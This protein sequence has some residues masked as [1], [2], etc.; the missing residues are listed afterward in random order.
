MPQIQMYTKEFC[1]FCIRAKKLLNSLGHDFEE[2]EISYDAAKE[3][4]MI[5]RTGRYTVPQIFIGGLAI[6]GSDELVA[7]V[8]NGDFDYL[9]K[10]ANGSIDNPATLSDG[11]PSHV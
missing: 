2:F 1:P 4:E 8:E 6:G 10:L 7:L 3:A 5:E 11:E 9:L